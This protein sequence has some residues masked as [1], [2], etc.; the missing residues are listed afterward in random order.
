MV[1]QCM[2]WYVRIVSLA[3]TPSGEGTPSLL[4]DQPL[5]MKITMNP[6]RTRNVSL[7]KKSSNFH[8][9][10]LAG[11]WE[12]G[13]NLMALGLG[14]M[15]GGSRS[16]HKY[17]GMNNQLT[18]AWKPTNYLEDVEA[19]PLGLPKTRAMVCRER[20]GGPEPPCATPRWSGS[21]N[22]VLKSQNW[23]WSQTVDWGWRFSHLELRAG[24]PGVLLDRAILSSSSLK[25]QLLLFQ[26]IIQDEV[27]FILP[28]MDGVAQV[29]ALKGSG[30]LLLPSPPIRRPSISPLAVST[31][32]SPP[33][34]GA[35]N[36]EAPSYRAHSWASSKNRPISGSKVNIQ[37]ALN[38]F[39]ALKFV[40][41]KTPR[42]VYEYWAVRQF[43]V[44]HT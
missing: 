3:V 17:A 20:R 22:S 34:K 6:S 38:S 2:S 9:G 37:V 4:G 29:N 1:W 36:R 10:G 11:H 30:W 15:G 14:D 33:L 44:K 41:G 42:S 35:P 18:S 19:L 40:L 13:D 8:R 43:Q 21:P 31:L 5:R 39:E 27:W 25:D 24:D 26:V 28:P 32:L 16:S 12:L 23:F 7:K